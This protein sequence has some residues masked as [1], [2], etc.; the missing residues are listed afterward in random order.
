L[1]IVEEKVKPERDKLGLNKDSAKGYAK[2]VVAVCK[3]EARA[4]WGNRGV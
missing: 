3:E 2:K 1:A 4:L